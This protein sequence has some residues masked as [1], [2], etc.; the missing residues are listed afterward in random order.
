MLVPRRQAA[1]LTQAHR[2]STAWPHDFVR[3]RDGIVLPIAETRLCFQLRSIRHVAGMQW[4]C[5]SACA[6]ALPPR[7]WRHDGAHRNDPWHRRL[8]SRLE[9]WLPNQFTGSYRFGL[10]VF[11]ILAVSALIGLST[12]KGRWRL[13]WW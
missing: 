12:I 7:D 9:P 4:S 1:P 6:S 10:L 3:L 11:A 13:A 5:L 8:L 2:H